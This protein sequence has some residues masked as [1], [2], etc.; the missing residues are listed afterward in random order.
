MNTNA[1]NSQKLII[2]KTK[3]DHLKD[4]IFRATVPE[5]KINKVCKEKFL[6]FYSRFADGF[7][8]YESESIW[9]LEFISGDTLVRFPEKSFNND[10]IWKNVYSLIFNQRVIDKIIENPIV[11]ENTVVGVWQDKRDHKI[12]YIV[13]TSVKTDEG[14][15]NEKIVISGSTPDITREITLNHILEVLSE[16]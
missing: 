2:E 6:R 15:S 8:I 13:G 14:W 16:C 11:I 4:E 1:D 10:N 12:V 9:Y 7:N 3:A 5:N